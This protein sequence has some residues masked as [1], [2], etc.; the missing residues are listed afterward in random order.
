MLVFVV[1]SFYK[2]EVYFLLVRGTIQRCFLLF[3]MLALAIQ[4][5]WGDCP[6]GVAT[7]FKQWNTLK[8]ESFNLPSPIDI[9]QFFLSLPLFCLRESGF[10]D[11]SKKMVIAFQTLN[12]SLPDA[13]SLWNLFVSSGPKFYKCMVVYKYTQCLSHYPWENHFLHS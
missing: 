11:L 6:S 3:S 12:I 7:M 1:T 8:R 4:R 13:H 2:Q 5:R 9:N 10:L